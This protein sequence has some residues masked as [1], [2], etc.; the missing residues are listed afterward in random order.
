MKLNTSISNPL[1][2]FQYL[3]D[4]YAELN[5]KL[6]DPLAGLAAINRKRLA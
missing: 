6:K 3:I 2:I 5:K 1:W 4:P